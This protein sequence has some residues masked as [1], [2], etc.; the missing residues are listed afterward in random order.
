MNIAT[1]NVVSAGLMLGGGMLYAL[2]ISSL[3]EM[4]RKVRATI[5]ADGLRADQDEEEKMI[6]EWIAKTLNIQ[7]KEE[8]REDSPKDAERVASLLELISKLEEEKRGRR[9]SDKERK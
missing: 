9:P 7:L 1:I 3:D 6:E 2:D 5:R 8:K 4:R